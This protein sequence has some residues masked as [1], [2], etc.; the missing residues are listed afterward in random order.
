MQILLSAPGRY[1]GKAKSEHRIVR[2]GH[3]HRVGLRL[4]V[5]G[6]APG[7]QQ[8]SEIDPR[9]VVCRLQV[10]GPLEFAVS[11]AQRTHMEVCLRQGIMR[12]G[13]VLVNLQ[14]VGEP[15][16][17]ASLSLPWALYRWP[18]SRYLCFRTFGFAEAPGQ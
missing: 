11:G 8:I 4:C 10:D 3:H 15:E 13:K 18:L 5:V 9:L 2:L 17:A 1:G 6:P 14:S 16:M 12:I 7:K